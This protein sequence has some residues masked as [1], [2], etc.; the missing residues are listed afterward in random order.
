MASYHC[1]VKVGGKGKAGAHALYIS[2]EGKYSGKARY[3]DLEATAC[4]N[5][6]P[7]AAH[8]SAHF[9]SAADEHERAN[10]ATYREIEVALPRELDAAQRRAL[11]EDFIGQEVGDKHAYQWAIHTPKAAL[12]KGEQPHAHI[13]YSERTR[14]G[15]ERD[16]EQY[17]KR[18]NGKAPSRG[19][20]RKDSAGTEERL[21]A[22]RQR[23]AEVQN[24]HLARHGH[25]D[26]VDHRSLK[27]RGISRVPE[28]HLGGSGVRALAEQDISAMLERRIAEGE[29]ERAQRAVASV[30]D[31]SG[32]LTAARAERDRQQA[33]LRRIGKEF[34]RET[35]ISPLKSEYARAL[36]RVTDETLA[37]VPGLLPRTALMQAMLDIGKTLHAELEAI[38]K[39]LDLAAVKR[40]AMQEPDHRRRLAQLDFKEESARVTL[41]DVNSMGLIKRVFY[42]T[43][44]MTTEAT[45][46]LAQV[47]AGRHAAE[48]AVEKS[49]AVLAAQRVNSENDAQR[50][51]IL[52]TMKEMME[53][54]LRVKRDEALFHRAAHMVRLPESVALVVEKARAIAPTMLAG[55]AAADIERMTGKAIEVAWKK[56]ENSREFQVQLSRFVLPAGERMTQ[57]EKEKQRKNSPGHE[58]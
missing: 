39:P 6:P 31:L 49:S 34:A 58:R 28:L 27:T 54:A 15:I 30:I 26:R 1:S 33:E 37:T 16:P 40:E 2:R 38:G 22:S 23:W 44:A 12:E 51:R 25:Q 36:G 45:E 32:D 20:C 41:D 10:G 47:E 46:L 8:N 5:M 52:G 21:Q 18:Y 50:R 42:D 13:M 55:M 9:W 53:M 48:A 4:G 19:G 7:W 57:Q 35:A 14:D 11:V 29:H 24:A 43:R 56:P 17:F 3:E